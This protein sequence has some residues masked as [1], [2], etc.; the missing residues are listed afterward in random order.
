VKEIGRLLI[1]AGVLLV[2][3]GALF[4][5]APPWLG[6][7]G[8]LPGDVVIRSKNSAFYFPIVTCLIVSVLVTLGAWLVQWLRK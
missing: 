2:L 4:L 8:R 6:K 7:L 5:W 1:A 3:L